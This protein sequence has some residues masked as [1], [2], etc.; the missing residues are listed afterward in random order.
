M[1]SA[2]IALALAFVTVAAIVIPTAAMSKS[3]A[4][5][6]V[7][8][9]GQSWTCNGPVD[10]NLVRVSNPPGDAVVLAAGCTGRIGRIEVDTRTA[11]GIKVQNS[12]RGTPAHDLRIGGGYVKCSAIAGG[13]HQDAVQAMGGARI[14]FTGVTFDC[15]GNSNFFVTQAGGGGTPTDIVCDGCRFGGKS[16]TTVRINDSVRS[17]VRN[18]RACAGR[19]VKQ[20]YYFTSGARQPVN[21]GNSQL[22][23]NDPLCASR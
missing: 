8:R 6:D 22:P 10:V 4:T 12:S 3:S 20:P 15:R 17:G 9:N 13:A 18:S 1:R 2:P 23:S 21:S 7:I 16:S 11:D 5:P 19:N 14:T